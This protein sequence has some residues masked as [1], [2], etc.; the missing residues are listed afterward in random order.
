MV[1]N[2]IKFESYKLGKKEKKKEMKWWLEDMHIE[3]DDFEHNYFINR[4][5]RRVK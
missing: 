2:R 5:L 1:P 4:E 3:L